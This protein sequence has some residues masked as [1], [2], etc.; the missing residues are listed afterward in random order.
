MVL[1]IVAIETNVINAM[2][3][4]IIFLTFLCMFKTIIFIPICPVKKFYD[5]NL[6]SV[7][8]RNLFVNCETCS[9]LTNLKIPVSQIISLKIIKA[10]MQPTRGHG[11]HARRDTYP[12]PAGVYTRVPLL[13]CQFICESRRVMLSIYRQRC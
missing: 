10:K 9:V 8:Q 13:S 1:K 5:F 3:S 2:S 4:V 11:P 7:Q 12:I 6:A